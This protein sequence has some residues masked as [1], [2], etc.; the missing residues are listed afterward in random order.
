LNSFWSRLMAAN[1]QNLDW[2]YCA[3]YLI[4]ALHG[5]FWIHYGNLENNEIIRY[6]PI[7]PRLTFGHKIAIALIALCFVL[8][9]WFVTNFAE[10]MVVYTVYLVLDIFQ[11]LIK[12]IDLKRMITKHA[13]K[14]GCDINTKDENCGTECLALRVLYDF[15]FRAHLFKLHVGFLIAC[16]AILAWIS[17]AQTHIGR[18][19]FDQLEQNLVISGYLLLLIAF[20]IHEAILFFW[21][22]QMFAALDR[23]R[24]DS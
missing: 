13:S 24:G 16:V 3:A 21:R 14:I 19:F 20:M 5:F 2:V 1:L 15:N 23:L 6:V 4:L 9:F 12:R 22:W 17:T 10:F 18:Q 8:L 11:L 7:V